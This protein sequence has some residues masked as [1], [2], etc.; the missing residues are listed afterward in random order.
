MNSQTLKA[1]FITT[2]FAATK[3]YIELLKL[4]VP[5][6]ILVKVLIYFNGLASLDTLLAPILSTLDLPVEAA[7]IFASS[8]ATGVQGGVIMYLSLSQEVAFSTSQVTTLAVMMLFVHSLPIELTI[9]KRLGGNIL[10]LFT[11][12]MLVAYAAGFM[13]YHFHS[14]F[15]LQQMPAVSP[16]AVDFIPN[17]QTFSEEL[18]S[19]AFYLLTIFSIIYMLLTFR[20]AM[21]KILVTTRMNHKIDRMFE[22]VGL[23]KNIAEVMVTGLMLGIVYGGSLLIQSMKEQTFSKYEIFMIVTFLSLMHS[24]IED[25]LLVLLIGANLFDVLFVKNF[26]GFIVFFVA[27][28]LVSKQAIKTTERPMQM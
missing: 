28:K 5:I 3:T 13:L 18:L 8:L 21:G 11:L 2:F 6:L 24:V 12:R 20:T 23:K 17:E 7:I 22:K 15:G 16:L 25:T 10:Y 19:H 26:I 4:I 14:H 1:V 27:I 9:S